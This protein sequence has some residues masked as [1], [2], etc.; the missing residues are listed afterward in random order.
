[1]EG[2]GGLSEED[3]M[4]ER[5]EAVIRERREREIRAIL[6]DESLSQDGKM[7]RV[8]EIMLRDFKAVAAKDREQAEA[9][10]ALEGQQPMFH[11][12][13][14]LG[15]SHYQ[16]KCKIRAHC[17]GKLFTCRLC[18]DD[19]MDHKICRFSTEE[20]MCMICLEVQ[21]VSRSC[22]HCG[23]EFARYFC[24]VC[25]LYDNEPGKHIY[26]CK[27][28]GICRLGKGVGID[29]YHCTKCNACVALV[30]K[31]KHRCLE[32]SLEVDCPVCNM[33]LFTSVLPVI[34]MPCGH[35]IHSH[36]Y[37]E[38]TKRNFTCPICAKS[39][40]DMSQLYHRI[41][42][43]LAEEERPPELVGTETLILCNDCGAKSKAPSHYI[44]HK[45]RMCFSYNTRVLERIRIST[46]TSSGAAYIA[47]HAIPSVNP[48]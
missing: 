1:M 11:A 35:T 7:S 37:E 15:C 22:R 32:R 38:Y 48:S 43:T 44:Y 34:F 28:C 41:D 18:H 31:E 23:E 30:S 27:D 8:K 9:N 47:A 39:L 36:C 2:G 46:P 14:V 42:E 40:A 4:S 17:C 5:D 19:A 24:G 29:N 20:V 16:R 10:L 45:C 33:F 26:H 3:G 12:E 13:G 21:P 25:K 6:R